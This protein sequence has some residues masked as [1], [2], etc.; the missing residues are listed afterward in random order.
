MARIGNCV[1]YVHSEP[2][3]DRAYASRITENGSLQIAEPG[4]DPTVFPSLAKASK[5]IR[6]T[7]RDARAGKT[8]M[9]LGERYYRTYGCLQIGGPGVENVSHSVRVE[10]VKRVSPTRARNRA[11]IQRR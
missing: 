4:E 1:V 10:P 8:Q 5:A 7:I 2:R 6:R 3:R 9:P 11:P